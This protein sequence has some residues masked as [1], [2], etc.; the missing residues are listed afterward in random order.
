MIRF[1][2]YIV[3]L[4]SFVLVIPITNYIT[5]FHSSEKFNNRFVKDLII[6][7]SLTVNSNVFRI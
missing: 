3:K 1:I 4:F 5:D 2:K 7:D 6:N